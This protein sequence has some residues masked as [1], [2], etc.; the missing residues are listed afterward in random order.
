MKLIRVQTYAC[1]EYECSYIC[2]ECGNNV[3]TLM[4]FCPKCGRKLEKEGKPGEVSN[5]EATVCAII[6]KAILS[7]LFKDGIP[8]GSSSGSSWDFEAHADVNQ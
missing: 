1:R 5:S 4:N 8:K 2:S 7:G 3:S 6:A